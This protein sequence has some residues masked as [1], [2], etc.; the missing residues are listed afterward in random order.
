MRAAALA[1]RERHEWAAAACCLLT[2]PL[3]LCSVPALSDDGARNAAPTSLRMPRVGTAGSA[4]TALP[5][6]K[7]TAARGGFEGNYTAAAQSILAQ[8]CDYT[9]VAQA[10]PGQS[11]AQRQYDEAFEEM[12]RKPGDLDVLFRFAAIA[13]QTGDLEGAI[14]ALE[15]MLITNPNL[16][17]VRLELGILYYRLGSYAVARTYAESVSKT[18]GLPRDLQFKAEQLT[19]QIEDKQSPSHFSGELFFGWRYQS[20][21]NFGPATSSIL[22][23]GQIADLNRGAIATPDF[24]AV[25]SGQIR[26]TYDLSGD[27]KTTLVTTLL[28]S[29]TRQFQLSVTNLALVDFTTG[30]RFQIFD[31]TFSDVTVRPFAAAGGIWVNDTPYYSSYGG[32]VEVEAL[33]SDDLRNATSLS[34]RRRNYPDT[35]FLPTNSLYRGNE[36]TATTNFQYAATPWL[37]LIAGALGQRYETDSSPWLNYH[38]WSVGAGAVVRFEDPV[39]ETALPWT[40]SLTAGHQW[41]AYDAPDVQVDSTR[42]RSLNDLSLNLSLLIPFDDR[43]TFVVTAGRIARTSNLPNYAFNNDI[44]MVGVS[45][46]PWGPER[47]AQL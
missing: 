47:K 39:L 20:N 36:F 24:G 22:L 42:V 40:I 5:L 18:P 41:W 30:P 19:T 2:I 27:N 1:R 3:L 35:W 13:A 9:N 23:F 21:A 31:G 45:W 25:A 37:T 14:A 7:V 33:L 16:V 12:L 32:G 44:V 6:P 28:A 15:R 4:P 43:T 11:E 17:G 26:H 46:R 34:W 10:V 38:T 29:A 8:S